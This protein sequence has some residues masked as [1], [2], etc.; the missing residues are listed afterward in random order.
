MTWLRLRPA[1]LYL[2]R[3]STARVTSVPT[4]WWRDV[5]YGPGTRNDTKESMTT[6]RWQSIQSVFGSAFEQASWDDSL[7]YAHWHGFHLREINYALCPAI[8]WE[9][10]EL[11]FRHELLALDRF[12]VPYRDEPGREVEREELLRRV[13]PDDDIY[14]VVELPR[15]PS[16]LNH[17][18]PYRRVP[19]LEALRRVLLRWPACPQIIAEQ[20][21]LHSMPEPEIADVE[22]QMTMFYVNTFF[23]CSGRAPIV[24]HTLPPTH[25]YAN[26]T[27]E[28]DSDDT[29]SS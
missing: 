29:D 8:L 20:S 7:A 15:E 2:L 14:T 3:H 13:F 22:K 10:A 26:P 27:D 28:L 6:K 23:Q 16:G 5:L 11:G 9:L 25:T 18:Q 17:P 21:V 19:W 12:L 4:Q 1:W 24:P